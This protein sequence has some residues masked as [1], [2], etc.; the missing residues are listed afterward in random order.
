MRTIVLA[1]TKEIHTPG[2]RSRENRETGT[3]TRPTTG[4]TSADLFINQGKRVDGVHVHDH[5]GGRKWPRS[6]GWTDMIRERLN[7]LSQ[8]I[9]WETSPT[10]LPAGLSST[11]LSIREN[12]SLKAR[13]TLIISDDAR[14]H[15][16]RGDRGTFDQ[17]LEQG[18][19]WRHDTLLERVPQI[20]LPIYSGNGSERGD[21]WWRDSSLTRTPQVDLPI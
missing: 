21:T 7:G 3:I 2:H 12:T 13:K 17:G 11:S 10:R 8:S 15:G 1:R 19:I 6:T 20:D 18:D 9:S 4:R 14:R 5:T 16:Y